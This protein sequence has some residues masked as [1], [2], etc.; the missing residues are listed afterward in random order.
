[1]L[2]RIWLNPDWIEFWNGLQITAETFDSLGLDKLMGDVE[3]WKLCQEQHYVLLTANRNSREPDSLNLAIAS[4][5]TAESLPVITIGDADRMK[6]DRSYAE[7]VALR[8]LEKLIG[9]ESHRGAG[10]LYVP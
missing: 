3:L 1:M 4:L 10:R 9:I 5:I 2:N 7:A 6:H 8:I